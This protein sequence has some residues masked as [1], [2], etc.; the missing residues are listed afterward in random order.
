MCIFTAINPSLRTCCTASLWNISQF[1]LS[2]SLFSL[3]ICIY[4]LLHL[5]LYALFLA[6]ALPLFLSLTI[7]YE[8]S[9]QNTNVLQSPWKQWEQR[10]RQGTVREFLWCW[11]CY[12]MRSSL[13]RA[14]MCVCAHAW[15]M[16]KSVC[17][18]KVLS[19]CLGELDEIR[20]MIVCFPCTCLA[21]L[22]R[23]YASGSSSSLPSSP[24]SC[25]W[26]SSQLLCRVSQL[27]NA[28]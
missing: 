2:L 21:R 17:F 10:G 8:V 23:V 25:S 14:C 24:L 15:R 7:A 5:Y 1:S 27:R 6:P 16:F 19:F 4:F 13:R 9:L 12:Q 26:L 22:H 28:S 3:H 20:P 11:H 18:S